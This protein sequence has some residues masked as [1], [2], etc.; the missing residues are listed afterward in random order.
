MRKP[1]RTSLNTYG[2]TFES[3]GRRWIESHKAAAIYDAELHASAQARERGIRVISTL[4]LNP[5][6]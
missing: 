3:E 6:S 4:P 1:I 5:Q 2:V